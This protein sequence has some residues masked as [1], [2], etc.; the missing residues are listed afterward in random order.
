MGA[1]T[2][3]TYIDPFDIPFLA[4]GH[5]VTLFEI[6]SCC[7]CAE[8]YIMPR[9][10]GE[11]MGT[12]RGFFLRSRRRGAEDTWAVSAADAAV[13]TVIRRTDG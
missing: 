4:N 1:K 13:R 5:L 11:S 12:A 6:A 10:C 7:P 8:R 9:R 3:S 2:T